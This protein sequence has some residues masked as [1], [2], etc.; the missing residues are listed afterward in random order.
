MYSKKQLQKKYKINM[1]KSIFKK[2]YV[3]IFH[4]NCYNSLQIKKFKNLF[5][6]QGLHFYRVKGE[7]T[8]ELIENSTLTTFTNLF[9]GPT[10]LGYFANPE[11]K[12]SFE[13]IIKLDEKLVLVGMKC[14]NNLYTS[15]QV[16]TPPI[17]KNLTQSRINY[18]STLQN[19]P[20]K[21]G[22]LLTKINK[23]R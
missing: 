2:N 13:K 11:N 1:I 16:S 10:I 9:K 3:F 8:Q 7:L 21:L 20:K 19:S 17:F 4:A 14:Y 23:S 15:V 6:M 22:L 12:Y 5:K 18:I